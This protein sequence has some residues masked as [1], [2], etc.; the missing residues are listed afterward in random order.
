MI[1]LICARSPQP[2]SED[3]F[4]YYFSPTAGDDCN[5]PVNARIRIV[6]GRDDLVVWEEIKC[7][8]RDA[9]EKLYCHYSAALIRYGI[10][11]TSETDLVED[12]LHDLFLYLWTNRETTTIKVSVRLYLYRAFR[13]NLIRAVIKRGE[14]EDCKKLRESMD[15]VTAIDSA[16]SPEGPGGVE[17]MDREERCRRVADALAMLGM[18]Q[19]EIVCLRFFNDL[20]NREIAQILN[21]REQTVKNVL[22]KSLRRLRSLITL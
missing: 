15:D 2:V 14:A 6:A 5:F 21:I 13:N 22:G 20:T 4:F 11:I 18:Q 12:T 9:L 3:D 10:H 16:R 1:M 8:S 17:S 7:G 19:R